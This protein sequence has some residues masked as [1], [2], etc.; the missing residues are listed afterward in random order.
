[1]VPSLAPKESLQ[2]MSN[3][4]I[5]AINQDPLGEQARL[6]RRY[7]EAGYDIWAGNLSASKMV[8]A[9]V[10]WANSTTRVTL[11]PLN[12]IGILAASNMRD[13]WAATDLGT[14]DG[15]HSVTLN[16]KAHE[17][18]ILVLADVKL[19]SPPPKSAGST[20][21]AATNASIAGG[22]RIQ[23]CSGQTHSCLPT[24]SKVGNVGNKATIKFSNVSSSKNGTKLIGVDYINYDVALSSAWNNG[25]NTRNLTLSVNG[26]RARLWAFPISGGDWFET[27]RLDVELDGFRAGGGNEIL[28][29]SDGR[30]WAPDVVG[31]EVYH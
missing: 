6:V 23:D 21:Y 10:N 24:K 11:N 13:V 8:V 2:I 4:E 15:S 22:A 30:N 18:K 3:K 16:L 20:Y 12:E 5:I 1:M 29:A 9:V 27:G 28:L 25:S 31:L 7:T 19:T 26:G 17:A 14:L